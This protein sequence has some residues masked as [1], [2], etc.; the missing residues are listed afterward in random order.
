MQT[1]FYGEYFYRAFLDSKTWIRKVL[2]EMKTQIFPANLTNNY[3]LTKE[4]HFHPAK[5]LFKKWKIPLLF[6]LVFLLIHISVITTFTEDNKITDNTSSENIE[7]RRWKRSAEI[8]NA[9]PNWVGIPSVHKSRDPEHDD[10]K[11]PFPS[12]DPNICLKGHIQGMR[13][14]CLDQPCLHQ[15]KDFHGYPVQKKNPEALAESSSME[16]LQKK[17][18]PLQLHSVRG[19]LDSINFPLMSLL[20]DFQKHLGAHGSVGL[21][22]SR[23][24]KFSSFLAS[25]IEQSLGEKLIVVHSFNASNRPFALYSASNVAIKMPTDKELYAEHLQEL[26]LSNSNENYD[27]L[28]NDFYIIDELTSSLPKAS[29]SKFRI[30]QFRIIS[31]SPDTIDLAGLISG[32]E[33]AACNLRDGGLVILN[34]DG[35]ERYSLP[36]LKSILENKFGMSLSVLAATFNKIYITT[37]NW[38]NKYVELILEHSISLRTGLTTFDV[39]TGHYRKS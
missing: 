39:A 4:F 5:S 27:N 33:S 23:L 24:D 28:S 37:T 11:A 29:L 1:F 15:L 34:F 13:A 21:I 35:Q 2:E 3:R 19:T 16:K 20:T 7:S 31:L 26:G 9:P 30:P 17:S 12:A 18:I 38:K 32:L 10:R 14:V 6:T 36:S 8:K 22:Q 25:S